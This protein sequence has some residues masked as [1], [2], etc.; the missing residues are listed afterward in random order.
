M[1]RL[2]GWQ[3]PCIECIPTRIAGSYADRVIA[4][5]ALAGLDLDDWQQYLLRYTLAHTGQPTFLKDGG[6]QWSTMEWA[7]KEIGV[8][9]SRQN[10]KGS[11]LEAL[12]LGALFVLR[13]EMIFHT[14]HEFKTAMNH[15]DRMQDLIKGCRKLDRYE[16]TVRKSNGS[17]GI[18]VFPDEKE[19]KLGYTKRRE[20]K[21]FTR[22]KGG[23]RGFSPDRVIMDEA[24]YV[25]PEQVSA[26]LF[27]MSARP[28]KQLVLTG[29]AG[30]EESIY[31]GS[32]RDRAMNTS[33]PP[34][35]MF[36]AEWSA[37][38][39]TDYCEPE[40]DEHDNP[41]DEEVWAKTNPGYGIRPGLNKADVMIEWEALKDSDPDEF[42]KERLGV[43]KWPSGAEQWSVIGKEEWFARAD[44]DS[45]IVD[46]KLV[47][48]VD[49]SPDLK[50]S[51]ITACG[52]N[53]HKRK[54]V[55]I[56]GRG[57]TYDYRPGS[58]WLLPR[59]LELCN[60]HNPAAI[61]IDPRGHAGYLIEYLEKYKYRVLS[62]KSVEYA[63][64]CG[65][66]FQAVVPPRGQVPTLTHFG[67][68]ALNTAVA[69]A[70]MREVQNYWTWDK[71][72]S[73][74]DIAPLVS[75]TLG[76]WGHAK[77]LAEKKI[78]K[79]WAMRM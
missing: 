70:T 11:Y 25:T 44:D 71:R 43:G 49:V 26:L 38:L 21:F 35:N 16:P 15:L 79:P 34:E 66:F 52:E 56:T 37:E 65:E 5:S 50:Y 9:V 13:E 63:Q 54:H 10:G 45:S 40:C 3:E 76:Y 27:A 77:I 60:E 51:A 14:A 59:L 30:T 75:A 22:T 18:T 6:R 72:L 61:I 29:S 64:A 33:E 1:S 2:L 24:M 4:L 48:A 8:M 36:W 19:R 73:N 28:N 69:A 55:E 57:S 17:E 58:T 20:L 46:D 62:P 39:H 42:F 47:F 32:M 74:A 23:G 68:A 12:E 7:A 41:S 53:L 67:Q 78:A 31:F